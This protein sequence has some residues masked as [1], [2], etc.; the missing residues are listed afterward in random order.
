MRDRFAKEVL[1]HG[2]KEVI[3]LGGTN[4]MRDLNDSVDAEVSAANCQSGSNGA[5]SG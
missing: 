5:G 4:D 2:Y 3:I 1:G